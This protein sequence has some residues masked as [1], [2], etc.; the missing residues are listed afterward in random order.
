MSEGGFQ[1]D[2]MLCDARASRSQHVDV[3]M[4]ARY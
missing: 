2:S 1:G 3:K 4:Q